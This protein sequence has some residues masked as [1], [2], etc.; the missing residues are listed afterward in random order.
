MAGG[1]RLVQAGGG[2]LAEGKGVV[3]VGG[4]VLAVAELSALPSSPSDVQCGLRTSSMW[5]E[6][7]GSVS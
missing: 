5:Q 1:E 2:V 4:G 3:L 6:G 7:R